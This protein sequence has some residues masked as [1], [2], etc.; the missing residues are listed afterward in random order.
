M[1]KIWGMRMQ[2]RLLKLLDPNITS[3]AEFELKLYIFQNSLDFNKEPAWI[4]SAKKMLNIWIDYIMNLI[5][6][7]ISL[8][9][10]SKNEDERPKNIHDVV[11]VNL[12]KLG[13]KLKNKAKKLIKQFD[14]FK[15]SKNISDL[16]EIAKSHYRDHFVS[17]HSEFKKNQIISKNF[18]VYKN[19]QHN[20]IDRSTLNLTEK[21]FLKGIF[22][23]I[24]ENYPF[25][26]TMLTID[27]LSV[28]FFLQVV[29]IRKNQSS[30]YPV[31]LKNT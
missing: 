28:A 16:I 9:N 24:I 10:D 25:K 31:I 30:N 6:N 23:K 20:E 19:D 1:R 12:T 7:D 29:R 4:N 2:L 27:Q 21:Q 3:E 17:I 26:D 5:E 13:R 11:T 22:N 18:L 15:T 8:L 14:Q